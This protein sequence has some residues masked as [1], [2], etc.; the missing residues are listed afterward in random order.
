[1]GGLIKQ[2]GKKWQTQIPILDKDQTN[3][4]RKYSKEVPIK[5]MQRL[6]RILSSL[7]AE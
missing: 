1:M 3:H 6:K 2:E 5:S 7:W 4:L